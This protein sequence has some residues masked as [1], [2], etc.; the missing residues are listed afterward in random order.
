MHMHRFLLL[1]ILD[2]MRS[3]FWG[4]LLVI[5][6]YWLKQATGY[7]KKLSVPWILLQPISTVFRYQLA[8]H[9]L[10]PPHF[11]EKTAQQNNLMANRIFASI[12]FQNVQ[13]ARTLIQTS[14][15]HRLSH[16]KSSK[17]RGKAQSHLRSISSSYSRLHAMIVRRQLTIHSPHLVVREGSLIRKKFS[18]PQKC[19]NLRRV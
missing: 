6:K 15:Y 11:T 19:K 16:S 3:P 12:R 17:I 14:V 7:K 10:S 9:F 5:T 1:Q 13:T 8:K 2:K 4:E 18:A